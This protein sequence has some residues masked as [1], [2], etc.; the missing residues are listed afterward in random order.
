MLLSLAAVHGQGV[1]HGDVALHNF[2]LAPDGATVWLLDLES[3]YL[4]DAS[5]QQME[6]KRLKHIIR[7][8]GVCVE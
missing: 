6:M 5:E 1:V 2:V 3:S 7:L 8:A 4:G